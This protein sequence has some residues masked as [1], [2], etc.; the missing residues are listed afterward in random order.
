MRKKKKESKDGRWIR[1]PVKEKYWRK[2]IA[3]W[4]ESGLSIRAF[5]KEHGV[6]E[7]SFYAWRRELIIR[8]REDGWTEELT[9]SKR[10]TPNVLKDGRGRMV[11]IRFRQT[12]QAGLDALVKHGQSNP[13]VPIKLLSGSQQAKE[14]QSILTT[15]NPVLKAGIE[16]SFPCGAIMRFNDNCNAHFV[17]ELFCALKDEVKQ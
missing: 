11:P 9:D 1:D 2:Q 10:I 8:A 17:A 3:L 15:S 14:P 13:F 16:I 5:C 4:Q 12:D 7:G 6:V